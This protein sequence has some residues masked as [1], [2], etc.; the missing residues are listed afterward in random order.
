WRDEQERALRDR[1]A[2]HAMDRATLRR[3]LMHTER[4]SLHA[5]RVLPARADLCLRLDANR[6][7]RGIET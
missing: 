6:A 3:F 7:V 2:P 5:L 4:L 1:G